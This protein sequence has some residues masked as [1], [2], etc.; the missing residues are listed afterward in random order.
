LRFPPGAA[1]VT[2]TG[3]LS[4]RHSSHDFRF[5]AGRGQTLVIH[6]QGAAIR[7]QLFLQGPI[8]AESTTDDLYID[9]PYKLPAAGTYT[10]T[11]AANTM[12]EGAYGPFRTTVTIK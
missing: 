12:A 7:G 2:I 10:F 3:A 5:A 11:F 6:E 4:A 9:T 8:P 1:S